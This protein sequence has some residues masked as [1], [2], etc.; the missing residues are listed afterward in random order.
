MV[1][2]ETAMRVCSKAA[3]SLLCA[4]SARPLFLVSCILALKFTC[5]AQVVTCDCFYCVEDL[6]TGVVAADV[7]KME[8][9]ILRWIDWKIPNDPR[10][11]ELYARELVRAG[12]RPGQTLDAIPV[13]TMF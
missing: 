3:Y 7:A 2:L 13:P 4:R 9:Q 12:L 5:D 6:F 10:V 11:Y 8:K 1:V